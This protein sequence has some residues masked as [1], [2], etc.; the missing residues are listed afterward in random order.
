MAV[1][2]TAQAFHLCLAPGKGI[3][4][5]TMDVHR[6]GIF[7]PG[8][9]THVVHTHADGIGKVDG[10]GGRIVDEAVLACRRLEVEN[11]CAAVDGADGSQDSAD[12]CARGQG[13]GVGDSGRQLVDVELVVAACQRSGVGGVGD[14]ILCCGV[15]HDAQGSQTETRDGRVVIVCGI[16]IVIVAKT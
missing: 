16:V 6:D 2:D 11:C 8:R 12:L 5:L 10:V 15:V 1:G 13:V 7:T 4:A 14:T 3:R 9:S